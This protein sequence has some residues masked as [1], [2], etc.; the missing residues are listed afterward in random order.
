MHSNK[1]DIKESYIQYAKLFAL[2]INWTA[3]DID[4]KNTKLT[5]DISNHPI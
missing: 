2:I 4:D 5:Y 3:S 1:F